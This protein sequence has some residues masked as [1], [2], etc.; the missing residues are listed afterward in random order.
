MG[1]GGAKSMETVS[2]RAR[3]PRIALVY[4]RLNSWGGAE[5]VLLA[6]HALYPEAPLFTS[7]YD[8]KQATWAKGLSVRPSWLQKWR[9]ARTHHRWLGWLM[10][11][12]FETLDLSGSDMV[13]SVTSEAAKGVITKPEQLHVCYLLTPTRYL[14]SHAGAYRNSL[15]WF[16]R[17]LAKRFQSLLRQWDRTASQRPDCVIPLSNLVRKRAQ[18]FYQRSIEKPIYPGYS[19]LPDPQQ[20]RH[21]PSG[22]F[23]FSWGRQVAYKRFDLIIQAAKKSGVSIVIAGDGPEHQRLV[24]LAQSHPTLQF[25]DPPTD[26]ELAWYLQHAEGAMFP[27]LEDFGIAPLEALSQ[28]CPV[29]VHQDSGVTELLQEGK[30]GVWIREES[31]QAVEEALQTFIN[32][33]WGRLDISSRARQYAEESFQRTWSQRL[34]LLWDIH[35]KQIEENV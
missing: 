23:F 27:Q 5:R 10:P 11:L 1:K 18:D 26:A 33:S 16:V 28:G 35:R 15:P 12:V 31:V 3:S 19:R 32:T 2:S 7:V 9:W 30:D 22:K 25:V 4:D 6:L 13:L 17:P 29:L 21:T 20:P 34:Q 8:R 14:W 24:R